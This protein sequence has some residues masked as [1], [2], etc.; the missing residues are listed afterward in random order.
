MAGHLDRLVM[1]VGEGPDWVTAST[2]HVGVWI[3]RVLA[4][5]AEVF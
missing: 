4:Q 3:D 5:H 2:G 1:T